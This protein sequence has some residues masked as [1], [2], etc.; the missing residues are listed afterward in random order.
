[1][2]RKKFTSAPRKLQLQIHSPQNQTF[3]T[4]FVLNNRHNPMRLTLFFLALAAAFI[5]GGCGKKSKPP[6][7]MSPRIGTTEAGIA[8]WYG[9]PYHGRRAANG[10]VYDMERLTAAHRTLPFETWVE[11]LNLS[12]QKRVTVR[13]TDR[14]PFIDGRIIDLSRAA[15]REIDLIGPGI[16][17]VQIRIVPPPLAS[18]APTAPATAPPPPPPPFALAAPLFAVQVGAFRDRARA[19]RIRDDYQQTYGAARIV[20]RAGDPP[21]WRVLVGRESSLEQAAALLERITAATGQ[22]AFV[23]RLDE[24][25]PV[26]RANP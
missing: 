24:P 11:V 1:M 14:G 5:T 21:L 20:I 6:I 15:A 19:E 17:Q 13:I 25:D 2:S 12:N 22:P 9:H 3:G 23:V 8:S 4:T 26:V 10:E 7:P 18:S 16:T